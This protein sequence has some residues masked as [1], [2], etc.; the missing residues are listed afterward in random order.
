MNILCMSNKSPVQ[1]VFFKNSTGDLLPTLRFLGGLY[2]FCNFVIIFP[3]TEVMMICT[4]LQ[5]RAGQQPITTNLWPLTSHIYHVMIIVIS[6]FSKK[7]LMSINVYF[8]DMQINRWLYLSSS[9]WGIPLH[10]NLF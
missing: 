5:I 8:N 7:F 6:S 4:V 2:N 9:P 1:K 3:L 10:C